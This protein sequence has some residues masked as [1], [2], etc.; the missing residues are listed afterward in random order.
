MHTY[1]E[2]NM[3]QKKTVVVTLKYVVIIIKINLIIM[4]WKKNIIGEE[5]KK[6]TTKYQLMNSNERSLYSRL[7]GKKKN[8]ENNKERKE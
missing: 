7:I 4:I 2:K 3:R 8:V 6:N 5:Q 1:Y